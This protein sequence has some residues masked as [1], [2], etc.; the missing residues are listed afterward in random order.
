MSSFPHPYAELRRRKVW[1]VAGAYALAGAILVG[2]ANDVLPRLALPEW[3]TTFVVVITLLGFP[4]ALLLAWAYEIRPEVQSHPRP[5]AA[6]EMDIRD[7]ATP[8]RTDEGAGVR[9]SLVVLP[10]EDLSPDPD[11]AFF[12]SGL[13]EELIADLSRVTSLRVISRTSSLSLRG[14]AKDVRTI[15]RELAVGFVLEGS[16]RRAGN[17]LRVTAQL[18]DAQRDAHLWV[19]KYSGTLDDI[20][21]LQE[22]ISRRIVAA[23]RVNL[24]ADEDHQLSSRPIPDVRAY[25]HYLRARGGI[26]SFD[27]AAVDRAIR[28]LSAGVRILGDNVLLLKGLGMAL[29]QKLNAGFSDDTSVIGEIENCAERIRALDP[30]DAASFLLRGLTL[31]LRADVPGAVVELRGAYRRD[32]GDA[33]TLLWLGVGSLS[34]GQAAFAGEIL[35]RL[36]EMDPLTPLSSLLVGYHAFFEGRF[37]D[38]ASMT[39]DTLRLGP[40]V[41]VGHW[42]AVRAFMAAGNHARARESAEYLA[43]HAPD[44]P[45]AEA[46]G[47]LYN[48]RSGDRGMP[49]PSA[50]LSAWACR[51]GEWAQY[52][53]DAY[54]A[55]GDAGKALEWL[56]A[57]LAAGFFNYAYLKL[58]DPFI[59]EYRA[60]PEWE[61]V[62]ER[63][64]RRRRLFEARLEPVAAAS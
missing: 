51:D 43:T 14:T 64:D 37:D 2:A 31:V 9:R 15:A 49:P 10:F 58:H 63:V 39:E 26:Y 61:A 32:P 1:R 46:A 40:D 18:I 29:F 47:L 21:D 57:A 55:G 27:G 5:S 42:Q 34:T 16:V 17:A 38:S 11:D 54:A 50:A 35:R 20:F 25:E 59:S 22:R 36:R 23:L 7:G 41:L 45:F 62:L 53:S 3:T 13:T 28:E 44:S 60:R 8:H 24:S 4:I 30:D 12:A 19:E 52:L 56:E 48:A 6:P 33:D